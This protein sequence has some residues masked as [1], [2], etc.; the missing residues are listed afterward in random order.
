MA[1]PAPAPTRPARPGAV[2]GPR[3]EV[4]PA[5]ASVLAPAELSGPPRPA[6]V[7]AAFPTA[8]YL[9]L[10][11]HDAVLP[12]L[13][14]DALLLPT[15]LRLAAPG[16]QV[17]WGVAVGDTVEVGGGRVRLPGLEVRAVRHCRPARVP[18]IP[19]PTPLRVPAVLDAVGDRTL[20][21]QATEV[22]SLALAGTPL[23][24]AVRALVG[25][26]SG[27]TPSG[28][29]ALCG[30]LLTLRRHGRLEALARLAAAVTARDGA[31]TSLSASLLRAAAQGYAVPQAVRLVTA[32]AT[33]TGVAATATGVTATATD[34]TATDPTAP[35][36]P[37]HDALAA[38]LPDVLA[39]GHTSGA[40]LVAGVAGA[41]AAL[42]DPRLPEGASRA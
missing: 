10:G 1:S 27:L 34:A 3:V 32:T 22:T 39:V 9:G 35:S 11:R 40:D 36:G 21:R 38:A 17:R 7:L 16:T 12:V 13:A 41:L 24:P 8:L 20:I 30:V 37:D 25:A 4:L 33:A 2:V 14:S 5:A 6:R 15:G 18:S 28:D 19:G 26:G 23:G 31:T 29:D 42:A